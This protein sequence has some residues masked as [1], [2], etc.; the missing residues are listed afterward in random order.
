LEL[1]VWAATAVLLLCQPAAAWRDVVL[2]LGAGVYNPSLVFY[3]VS[4]ELA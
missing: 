4:G 3:E 2:D 1:V